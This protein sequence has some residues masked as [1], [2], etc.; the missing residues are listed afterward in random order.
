MATQDDEIR[1]MSRSVSPTRLG[2]LLLALGAVL[3]IAGCGGRTTGATDVSS[4][5]ATLNSVVSCDAGPCKAYTHWRAAGAQTWIDGPVTNFGTTP[6]LALHEQVS[7]LLPGTQY[8][9]QVCWQES[10][11]PGY[12][13]GCTGTGG[14]SETVETFTTLAS[15][16]DPP[17]VTLTQPPDSSST[18][19]PLLTLAGAAGNA[20]GD[21]TTVTVKIYSGP[22][23]SGSLAQSLDTARSGSSWSTAPGSNL[24]PGTYTARAQQSDNAGNTGY[25]A[26]STFTITPD[27][28]PPAVGLSEPADGST[29]SDRHPILSGAAGDGPGDSGTVAVNIYSGPDTSGPLVDTVATTR[30][31]ATW[32]TNSIAELGSG[33]YTARAQQSDNAGNTGYSSTSTFTVDTAAPAVSLTAPPNGSFTSQLRPILSGAAGDLPGDSGTVTVSI[34]SGPSTS[35]PLADTIATARTGA[36]WSTTPTHDLSPGTYTAAVEQSDAAGNIGQGVPA[37]FTVDTVAPAVTLTQPVAGSHTTN[38]RPVLSGGAGADP[39]DAQAVEVEIYEGSSASG[40]PLATLSTNRAGG[41]WSTA[42]SADLDPGPYTARAKQLDSAGNQGQS[43]AVTF[44]VDPDTTPPSPTLTEP[45]D[46][47]I[48]SNPRPQ[49]SGGAGNALGDGETVTVRIY[50]GS[51]ATGS[52]VQTLTTARSGSSWSATPSSDLASG[53]YTALA[54]QSDEAGNTGQSDPVTFDV[55][56]TPPAVTLTQPADG[57]TFSN[58]W[59]ALAGGAGTEPGD[60]DDVVVKIYSGSSATGSPIQ[61]VTAGR[62]GGST[63]S[64]SPASALSSGTYTALAEQSDEAGNTGASATSTFTVDVTAPAVTLTQP[65][66]GTVT[67]NVRPTLSGAAGDDL[68]DSATVTVKIYAGTSASGTPVQT[69]NTTRSGATW[70]T[71]PTSD[72]AFGTYTARAEQSDSAGNLGQSNAETFTVG[73]YK[74]NVMQDSPAAY[75]RLG[76]ASGTV[77]ADEKGASPGAYQFS[78]SLGQAGVVGGDSNTAVGFDGVDDQVQ[79][80]S[81]SGL[82]PTS[83]VSVET[84]LRPTALPADTA[85]LLRK[86]QQYLLRLTSAGAVILRVWKTTTTYSELQTADGLVSAGSWFHVVGTFN[87][88][89]MRIFLNGTQRASKTFS[90]SVNTTSNPLYIGSSGGYDRLSGRLDETAVYPTALSASR[91]QAHYNRAY[92]IDTTPPTVSLSTPAA[93]STME[94]K[95][96]FGGLGGITPGDGDSVTVKLYAGSSASGSPIQTLNASRSAQGVFSVLASSSLSSGT[97]TAQAEQSDASGNL[98]LS[99]AKT[100]TVNATADPKILAAGDIGSCSSSGDDATANLLDGLGGTVLALGDTVYENGTA[101]EYANCYDPTWGRH[102]ARTRPIVGDH[103]YGTSGASGYFN[104]F[105]AAAGPAGANKGYYSYDLGAWHVIAMNSYCYEA[106]T[107]TTMEDWLQNDLEAHSNVCT[108]AVYHE[109]LFSSGNVHGNNPGAQYLWQLLYAAGADVMLDGSEH[110]YERFAP[111]TPSGVANPN[112]IREFIVGTGGRSLYGIGTVQPNS[113]ARNT[114]AYGVLQM[115]LH[116]TSYDWQFIP[117]AGKSFTDSGTTS[118][119]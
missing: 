117:E 23:T 8:E 54:E 47:S 75:W 85:T 59:P 1:K 15:D 48:T 49:L 9:Y 67:S 28:T 86:D 101:A 43:A 10:T 114:D 41:S 26:T 88:S 5:S 102:K 46:G 90:S 34:Y 73:T 7:G 27:N 96:N 93:G 45:A 22:D 61:T 77:A 55:D 94:A 62:G 108:M 60:S 58:P 103:E 56:A 2:A 14:H 79:V 24:A 12:F 57:S 92:L 100:F 66:P 97:Y 25:S 111:Q 50:A 35:G 32:S 71:N 3:L 105:G 20:P 31:G 76:E 39:G 95:P 69:V 51:S 70:S 11:F 30:T 78:P 19:D 98:G 91:V 16:T 53:T 118:C 65:P 13:Y 110:I 112:G 52:P 37:T 104:Y 40:S 82:N 4:A 87:G 72:L 63:W 83:A 81:T 36:T 68:G 64:T 80:A 99:A 21:S 116:P 107:C 109:P 38:P 33:T 84:W 74:D 115:T 89:T 6:S 106:D 17:T 119:H 29:I 113:E 18:P 42:P 44:T